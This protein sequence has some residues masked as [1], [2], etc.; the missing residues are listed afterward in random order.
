MADLPWELKAPKYIGVELT[1]KLDGWSSPKDIILK[2]CFCFE[3]FSFSPL[4]FK[5]SLN[6]IPN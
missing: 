3:Q 4:I 2:V 5:V 1:G 6:I